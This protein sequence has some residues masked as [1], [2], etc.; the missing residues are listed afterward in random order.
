M[1]TPRI[2]RG[3]AP[4]VRRMAMSVRLSL[5]TI[6]SVATMLKAATATI[7]MRINPI[8]VF[9]MRIVRKYASFSCVQSRTW[10]P[11]GR[12]AREL[13]RLE[14][15]LKLQADSRRGGK[16]SQRLG[17]R[18]IDEREHAVVLLQSHLE[19]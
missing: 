9:S 19:Y 7:S 10:Y 4:K 17:V 2:F 16:T 15:V 3:D 13:G 6:T 11:P 18:E 14:H 8:M 12:R 5:T 1:K